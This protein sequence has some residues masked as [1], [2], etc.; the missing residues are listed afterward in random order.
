MA[1]EIFA[2]LRQYR[3]PKVFRIH[4][5]S[6]LATMV[7][8]ESSLSAIAAELASDPKTSTQDADTKKVLGQLAIYAW[9]VQQNAQ[10]DK[11]EKIQRHVGRLIDTLSAYGITLLDKVGEA[12]DPGMAMEVL[13]SEPTL[14]ITRP[15]ILETIQPMVLLHD[16]V[17]QV[18]QVIVGVP[19]EE[20]K[21]SDR[22]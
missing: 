20:D 7:E 4:P 16:Q 2:S 21:K 8:I 9:R 10:R 14:G 12:Y 17:L 5:E 3:Y 19:S 11:Q 22:R 1:S 15:T 13:S 18:A 6:S